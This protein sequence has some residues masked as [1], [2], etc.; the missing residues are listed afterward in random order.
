M[1]GEVDLT[2]REFLA[3]GVAG[4]LAARRGFAQTKPALALT[5]LGQSLILRDLAAQG[6]PG[7][8]AIRARLAPAD[9]RF[10]NLE[11][12]IRG[13][14]A[15]AE[16]ARPNGVVGDPV[17]LDSLRGL[18]IELLSLASNHAFDLNEAGVLSTLQEVDARGFTH[19]GT[20][21]TLVEA[22]GAGYR[23]RAGGSVALIAMASNALPVAAMAAE[24]HPGIQHLA[25]R[26]NEV[27]PA[28]RERVLESIKAAASRARWVIV[29]QHDHYWAADW[30]DTPEWKQRWCRDCIDAG[31]SI[32]VSHGVPLLHGIEIHKGR[33]IFYGLG[34]F[35][36]HLALHLQGDIPA[37][38][39]ETAC[40]QSVIATC[41]FE[42]D[43]IRSVTLDPITL[44]SDAGIGEGRYLLHGNP[45]LATAQEATDILSRLRDLSKPFGTDL[46]ITGT[47]ARLTIPRFPIPQLTM[48]D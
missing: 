29:Y 9:L 2:R 47:T 28:D 27:V 48:N 34:N 3:G 25:V 16:P 44:K 37:Q 31:A 38:Y 33:P 23:D 41:E 5:V 32:Y 35:V 12:A 45:R 4:V 7:Y 30:H 21:R 36:F 1:K 10:S 11:V 40:W 19:A 26:N 46:A 39:R 15:Q 17:V 42:G 13:R 18:P 8:D 43:T 22:S 24:G 6:N 14:L 20:G